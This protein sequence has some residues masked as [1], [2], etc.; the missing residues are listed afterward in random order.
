MVKFLLGALML[1]LSVSTSAKDKKCYNLDPAFENEMGYC[2]A[3]RIGDTL[4]IAGTAASGDMPVAIGRVYADLKT[5]LAAHG[6]TFADVVKETVYATDLDGFIQHHQVRKAMYTGGY[7]VATW[8]QV[9]RLFTPALVVEVE[10]VA[11]FPS[12]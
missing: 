2:Q 6:L 9:P 10:L 7:P 12:K 11:V 5:T 4:Y 8:L 3:V 1:T